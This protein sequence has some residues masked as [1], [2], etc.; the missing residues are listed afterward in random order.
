MV[1]QS[2]I[3]IPVLVLKYF[4]SH[5]FVFYEE[6]ETMLEILT[7]LFLEMEHS[8]K[9]EGVEGVVRRNPVD[10]TVTI[11]GRITIFGAVPQR[12]YWN[13]A[14]PPTRGI[15]F[16]GSGQ[17]YPNK[18]IAYSNTPNK[19]SVESSDGSFTIT[20]QGIPA[21]YFTGLGSTYV[22]P[23]VE[24]RSATNENT[25][26][27]VTLWINDTAAPY[28]WISGSPATMRPEVDTPEST[29]RSMYYKGRE[30]LPLFENQ[31]AQLR[32]K[33]YP[34]DMTARGWPEPDD[35]HPWTRVPPP[36]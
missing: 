1:L 36:A 35:E 26:A 22:P 2:R 23:V 6:F 13:A 11:K 14:A 24:F 3:L 20:L 5:S 16:A 15:G 21:G 29:G 34:G 7:I 28:R 12:I 18:L 8:S 32:A 31:E 17:P 4:E 30:Q 19:G 25:N 27:L 9:G 33:G 10:G